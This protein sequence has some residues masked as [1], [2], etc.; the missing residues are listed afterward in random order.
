[1]V[2]VLD[3]KET[4]ITWYRGSDLCANAIR[5]KQPFD[6]DRVEIGEAG[7]EE[8]IKFV[9]NCQNH[10]EFYDLRAMAEIACPPSAVLLDLNKH[11]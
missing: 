3:H 2:A 1:M 9:L 5:L 7:D 10:P 6:F 8:I 11:D 4:G